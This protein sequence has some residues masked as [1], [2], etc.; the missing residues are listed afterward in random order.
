MRF[1][2][3]ACPSRA[4]GGPRTCHSEYDNWTLNLSIVLHRVTPNYVGEVTRSRWPAG[5][6]YA[7]V[8]LIC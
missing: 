7:S 5:P 4:S 6:Y 3:K 1:Q 8:S 2:G